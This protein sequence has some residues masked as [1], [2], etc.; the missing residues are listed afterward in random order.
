MSIKEVDLEEGIKWEISIEATEEI[1]VAGKADLEAAA[2][3]AD[4]E[5]A[6]AAVFGEAAVLAAQGRCTRQSALSAVLSVR[7]LSSLLKESQ[8][9][10]GIASPR[11]ESSGTGSD[12]QGLIC[13][14][15][16]FFIFILV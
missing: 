7:C 13:L 14:F 12:Y 2:I 8:S 3:E 9:F 10:A 1:A 16:K 15:F 6:T 5:E 11:S 4:L